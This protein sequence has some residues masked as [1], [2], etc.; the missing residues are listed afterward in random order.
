MSEWTPATL[1][2]RLRVMM[3]AGELELPLPAAGQ[4]PLRH[5]ALYEFGRTD[6]SIARLAEAHTD[7]VAIL[8]EAQCDPI[9]RA[10]YGVWASHGPSGQLKASRTA[11]GGL[12]L[13]GAKEFCSGAG[14]V[15]AAL[16]SVHLDSGVQLVQLP[17]PGKGIQIEPARWAS[18]AFKATRTTRVLFRNVSVPARALIGGVN[19]YLERVGFWHGAIGPGACWAGG[20]AGLVDAAE[21]RRPRNAH[22]LAQLGAL[23]AARW[24]LRVFLNNAGR[25]IDQG[26]SNY[27]DARQRALI[28]R[29]LIERTCTDVL[30]RFGRVTGPQLLAF[31]AGIAR[32]HTELALYIRQCHAERDMEGIA[33]EV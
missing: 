15:D 25:E 32:R 21:R 13:N 11:R 17:L 27:H 30:D 3:S 16:V 33:A 12:L 6:L 29:H 31:D 2:R 28:V 23:E 24:S 9:R 4:T 19:W 20:A 8:R 14:L 22:T 26:N 7:A 18:P 5:H 1:R 10:L